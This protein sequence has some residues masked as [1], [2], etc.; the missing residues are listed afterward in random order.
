MAN[1]KQTV[2][3]K[4]FIRWEIVCI[5]VF[6]SL[7]TTNLIFPFWKLYVPVFGAGEI[8]IWF[9][10]L[11]VALLNLLLVILLLTIRR[12]KQRLAKIFI[13]AL[14]L[15]ILAIGYAHNASISSFDDNFRAYFKQREYIVGLIKEEK[16]KGVMKCLNKRIQHSEK[17]PLN[18]QI[19]ICTE[20]I[21]LPEDYKGLSFGS[22]RLVKYSDRFE[23]HFTHSTYGFGDG[24]REIIYEEK[25]DQSPT[26]KTL[27]RTLYPP[28]H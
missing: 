15:V 27:G 8:F 10:A 19:P 12:N 25:P 7:Y 3:P 5:G 13:V 21:S 1:T 14:G 22:T 9:L 23:I 18:A 4:S 2:Q 11:P 6:L 28:S 26:W 17:R 20:A 16:L 24:S